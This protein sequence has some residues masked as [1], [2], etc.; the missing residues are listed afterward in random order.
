[1]LLTIGRVFLLLVSGVS[2]SGSSSITKYLTRT[3][4]CPLF[5]MEEMYYNKMAIISKECLIAYVRC[6][7]PPLLYLWDCMLS[8][9]PGRS[10][11]EAVRSLA[12]DTWFISRKT[13]HSSLDRCRV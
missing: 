6:V 2:T 4:E 11:N 13:F 3:L 9:F 5:V 10:V 1:M 12:L 8:G 7:C